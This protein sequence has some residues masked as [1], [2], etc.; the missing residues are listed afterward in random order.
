MMT[1]ENGGEFESTVSESQVIESPSAASD[2]GYSSAKAYDPN[3]VKEV[4]EEKKPAE[5]AKGPVAKVKSMADLRAV[6]EQGGLKASTTP[7]GQ[8]DK[9][10]AEV[11]EDKTGSTDESGGAAFTPKLQV[12]VRNKPVAI[13]DKFKSLMTDEKT[14]KE[15]HELFEKS[16]GLDVIK[17]KHQEL[18]AQS[19][20]MKQNLDSVMGSIQGARSDYQG[21]VSHFQRGDTAGAINAMDNFFEK[22]KVPEE[23]VLRYALEKAKFHQLPADQQQLVLDRKEAESK[24]QSAQTTASTTEQQL[25]ESQSKLLDYELASALAKP[26][27]KPIS[28][29]FDGLD[30]NEPGSFRM[31]I[32]EH[33]IEQHRLGKNLSPEQAAQAVIKKF[34]LDALA[35]ASGSTSTAASLKAAGSTL[36]DEPEDGADAPPPQTVKKK[37]VASGTIPNVGSKGT[38]PTKAPIRNLKQLK[39]LANKFGT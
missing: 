32:I 28:D 33:G 31:A 17:P 9:V 5:P 19:T 37:V 6:A 26:E 36:E 1:I 18:I 4:A 24:I 39:E 35:K 12:M 23:V 2:D 20:Q 29:F 30:G 22:L 10:N 15:I 27:V 25:A 38:S 16:A 3:P 21:A 11:K 34:R 8:S 13:P 7:G 14:Q